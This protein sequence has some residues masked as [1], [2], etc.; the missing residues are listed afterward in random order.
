MFGYGAEEVI[1]KKLT[2][3]PV[4]EGVDPAIFRKGLELVRRKGEYQ[5]F[6]AQKKMVK[7]VVST[8]E[9]TACWMNIKGR[10]VL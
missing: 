1:G 7:S 9:S 6:Y 8:Q 4:I 5:F 10:P 2:N 3:I